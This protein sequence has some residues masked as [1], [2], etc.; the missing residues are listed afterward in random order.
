MEHDLFS[1]KIDGESFE[2]MKNPNS[3]TKKLIQNLNQYI[4]TIPKQKRK[5]MINALFD[6]F[7]LFKVETLDDLKSFLPQIPTFMKDNHFSKNDL[8]LF[9]HIIY[10]MID[11]FASF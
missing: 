7:F 6:I 11:I 8:F 1:W 5:K 3:L 4:T 10:S 9:L 2:I